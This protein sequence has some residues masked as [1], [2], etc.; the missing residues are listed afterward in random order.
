MADLIRL[1]SLG[2][3]D[4]GPW[5]G[6]H[7]VTLPETGLVLV[8]GHVA[9]TSGGSG[10]G[11]S[12]LLNGIA[13]ALGGCPFSSS[14]LQSW[15]TESPPE[16]S[17]VLTRG[18]EQ[19]VVV[20]TSKGLEIRGDGLGKK[21]RVAQAHLD[22]WFGMDAATRSI[23]TYRPQRRPGMFLDLNSG[24]KVE[25]LCKLL[26]LQQAEGQAEAF[27][28]KAREMLRTLEAQRGSVER[29]EASAADA[30][31]RLADLVPVSA[32]DVHAAE[33][34]VTAACN[35]T[36][37][38]EKAVYVTAKESQDL[39]SHAVVAA[40]AAN[41][42]L[43]AE[44]RELT[45]QV[46]E[47]QVRT[48]DSDP[49]LV[50]LANE[51]LA[52]GL[53]STKA[54]EEFVLA[55]QQRAAEVARLNREE[56]VAN[57]RAGE[58]TRWK[59]VGRDALAALRAL[60]E[61]VCP[62]CA[63]EWAGTGAEAERARLNAEVADAK[64]GVQGAVD[65]AAKA[66]D[67]RV[68]LAFLPPVKDSRQQAHAK[69]VTAQR[70]FEAAKGA[71]SLYKRGQADALRA[72]RDAVAARKVTY[73]V[74]PAAVELEARLPILRTEYNEAKMAEGAARTV[75]EGMKRRAAVRETVEAEEARARTTALAVRESYD[76]SAREAALEADAGELLKRFLGVVV[77]EALTEVGDSASDIL[78][79]VANT[80][81]V[82]VGFTLE[83]ETDCGSVVRRIEPE[84]RVRG[85]VVPFESGISGGM[86]TPVE[87]AVDLAFGKVASQRRG[88]Y[89]GWLVL[90]EA[91][92]GLGSVEKESCLEML[93]EYA[94]D[95][96]V[97]VVDHDT[98]FQGLFAQT[99]HI[100]Q[101]DG[102]ASLR[103]SK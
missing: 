68:S 85:R 62:T 75:L 46:E 78:A 8:H 49:E 42:R 34:A 82:S 61:A 80:A 7:S 38:C 3:E 1:H 83:R 9:E 74:P 79:R 18:N 96:L 54:S 50:R 13:H 72:Q 39:R 47:I 87:L 77:D 53:A 57:T 16:A 63:Q 90:D 19:L 56:A 2:L 17:V 27:T 101:S 66:K 94:S 52:A 30:T 65:A 103:S 48:P 14:D 95:R 45:N 92:N 97:L 23:A 40:A 91:L 20:R 26:G 86:Q 32:A 60:D 15:Y 41:E 37:A 84:I 69:V 64:A 33:R 11:K 81:H 29:A 35:R 12:F 58:M 89:P 25:F 88:S 22:G 44:I 59:K 36:I 51:A 24:E 31:K 67:A 102:R 21:G 28:K 70:A 73:E 76:A 55:S 99:L 100:E 10:A 5:V 4:F 43:D 71:W 6:P 98:T 93:G